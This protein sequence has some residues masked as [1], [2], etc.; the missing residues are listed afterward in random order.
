MKGFSKRSGVETTE[1]SFVG[2]CNKSN[3][4]GGGKI[5]C[6]RSLLFELRDNSGIEGTSIGEEAEFI[7]ER[8]RERV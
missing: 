7:L 2:E 6:L 3:P 5:F 1:E 8:L 4:G